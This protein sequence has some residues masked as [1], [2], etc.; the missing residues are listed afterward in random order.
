M[1]RLLNENDKTELLDKIG[2]VSALADTSQIVNE[3]SGEV[4][5]INDSASAPLAGLSVFGKSTQDGTP[6]PTAPIEIVSAE[7]P[8]VSICGKNL[9]S[10]KNVDIDVEHYFYHTIF[11]GFEP[12]IGETY[13]LSMNVNCSVLPFHINVGCGSTSYNY[14]MSPKVSSVYSENGRISITFVWNLTADQINAGATKL[15]LRIPRFATETTFKAT[16]SDIMLEVGS[17]ATEYEPYKE[18]QTLSVP[19]TL[20]GIPVTS[21]GNYTDENGQQWICDE[22]DFERGVYVRRILSKTI[23][24]FTKALSY[25]FDGA[26]TSCAVLIDENVTAYNGLCSHFVITSKATSADRFNLIDKTIYF[27]LAGELTQEEWKARMTEMKPTVVGVLS[28]PTETALSEEELEA[29]KALYANK[30]NTTIFNDAG[31]NMAVGY[32]ADPKAYIDNKFDEL[33]SLITTTE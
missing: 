16:I 19:Y 1:K 18:P 3:K 27:K 7:N 25:A 10:C 28:T 14:D 11:T 4:I 22:V 21:G 32:I 8:E 12:I 6:T 2:E 30:P 29:Y 23:T 15:A 5:A 20:R 13:T 9:I 26:G 17:V 33:Q 31:A 24:D